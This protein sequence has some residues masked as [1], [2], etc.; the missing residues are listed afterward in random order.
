MAAHHSLRTS[1]WCG[2]PD[3]A[4]F[5]GSRCS[6]LSQ[7]CQLTPPFCSIHLTNNDCGAVMLWDTIG[8]VAISP[9][10]PLLLLGSNLDEARVPVEGMLGHGTSE[11]GGQPPEEGHSHAA[12][13]RGA[14][15]VREGQDA[16]IDTQG[17]DDMGKLPPEV[18]ERSSPSDAGEMRNVD[19]PPPSTPV[20]P[21]WSDT[22]RQG[23]QEPLPFPHSE[24]GSADSAGM[25]DGEVVAEEV[26]VSVDTVL[27]NAAASAWQALPGRDGLP[28][29][30]S[31]SGPGKTSTKEWAEDSGRGSFGLGEELK[32][33][34]KREEG[35]GLGEE[36]E[37]EEQEKEEREQ[38]EEEKEEE[39]EQEEEE[40]EEEGNDDEDRQGSD[41]NRQDGWDEQGL[42]RGSLHRNGDEANQDGSQHNQNEGQHN[43]DG[44]QHNQDGGQHNQDG[45]QHHQDGGQHN[46][47]GGQHENWAVH[48]RGGDE[49]SQYRSERGQDGGER[50]QDG[51]VRGQ[52]GS[53]QSQDGDE[54]S[55]DG[56]ERGQDGGERGQD[57]GEQSH[58][59]VEHGQDGGE[60]SHDGVEHGQDGGEHNQGGGEHHQGGGERNQGG[61]ER[62]QGGGERNQGG[63]EHYDNLVKQ[64]SEEGEHGHGEYQ[65][66]GKYHRHEGGGDEDK[67]RRESE[68]VLDKDSGRSDMGEQ[69]RAPV[70]VLSTW[71]SLDHAHS[72]KEEEGTAPTTPTEADFTVPPVPL[73]VS[74]EDK[75]WDTQAR[76]EVF[77]QPTEQQSSSSDL[78][79]EPATLDDMVDTA[80]GT[81]PGQ[82]DMV[83][84]TVS[85]P[86]QGETP[87]PLHPSTLPTDDPSDPIHNTVPPSDTPTTP[88]NQWVGLGQPTVEVRRKATGGPSEPSS[89]IPFHSKRVVEV[90]ED[91]DKGE[92][93][94]G[95]HLVNEDGEWPHTA[96]SQLIPL[97]NLCPV[98]TSCGGLSGSNL[99]VDVHVVKAV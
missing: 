7:L 84:H 19:H 26:V 78:P 37:E 93:S 35:E 57:G 81:F 39:E 96:T 29:T 16:N 97:Q 23:K 64:H 73:T 99:Y 66:G 60:Q 82:D 2:V 11:R 1:K 4:V 83:E 17:V 13:D 65:T 52:D 80:D 76:E 38:E 28:E 8:H 92:E 31:A 36:E 43:Q 5:S 32:E 50:G 14:P 47:D 55:Q 48:H 68:L 95:G 56:G 89:G 98:M 15:P 77:V 49:H 72:V 71:H 12:A 41:E 74:N 91:E 10:P 3:G 63:G 62:N 61:G 59:G 51:G 79:Q 88:L 18:T 21:D 87:T 67:E 22:D 94:P 70:D 27:T 6:Q 34:N 53:E 25:E 86:L 58:D 42:D 20:A 69:E 75:G 30:F 54:R 46:Q 45:G 44:G 90:A 24:G 33:E 85:H 9:P 40:N